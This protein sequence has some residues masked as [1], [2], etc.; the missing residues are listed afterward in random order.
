MIRDFVQKT[1]NA[2]D[3]SRDAFSVLTHPMMKQLNT[4]ITTVENQEQWFNSKG[5]GKSNSFG[6]GFAKGSGKGSSK[7]SGKGSG[8]NIL[9]EELENIK[10]DDQESEYD[11]QESV[12]EDN[13]TDDHA[14]SQADDSSKNSGR[15]KFNP[16]Q[17]PCPN[18]PNVP[19]EAIHPPEYGH[20]PNSVHY[21]CLECARSHIK[22][23]WRDANSLFHRE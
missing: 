16:M 15:K 3:G 12:H 23:G 1:E 8:K 19:T 4:A 14:S 13:Q 6:K 5:K 11:D 2:L 7:G 9:V 22:F 10:T 21:K 20:N 18:C 17:Y